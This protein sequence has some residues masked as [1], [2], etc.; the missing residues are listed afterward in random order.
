MAHGIL[1]L[2]QW[3]IKRFSGWGFTRF[4]PIQLFHRFIRSHLISTFANVDGHKMY[5]DQYDTLGL[6]ILGTYEPCETALVKREVKAGERVLDIGANIG[7]F[8]L[9]FARRVGPSGR[10]YAFEP[11]PTNFAILKRN[12]ETN[13]YRNVILIQKAVSNVTRPIRL[14]L[15]SR[16]KAD[17]RI[18]D[19]EDNRPSVEIEATRLDDYFKDR[20]EKISFIK[21]DIQGA[22]GGAIQGMRNIL[23]DNKSVRLL[24]EFWPIGLRRFGVEA[25]EYLYALEAEG[26]RFHDVQKG[27]GHPDPVEKTALLARYVP[28]KENFTNL[29]CV[30]EGENATHAQV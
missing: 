13:G 6:S 9:I 10:V 19:S 5:L 1:P 26:F 3:A 27:G 30:R 28:E 23:R 2:Y 17:H 18:Y 29:F 7:Y 25:R 16:N 21:M 11:D 8:T 15:A 14:Y 4:Y 24:T 22:E 12:V 20:S